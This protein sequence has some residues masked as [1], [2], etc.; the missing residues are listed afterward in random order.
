[1]IKSIARHALQAITGTRKFYYRKLAA[2]APSAKG[3]RVLEIGS[4]K[5]VRGKET[6]SAVH[7]FQD[8]AEF[9][10]TD[11]NPEFGHE[12]LDITTMNL[13]GKYD[14]ILCLNVLEHVYDFQTAIQNLHRAL[15]DGGRLVVAVP[16]AFPMHDEPHDY[17]RYTEFALRRMLA[18]FQNI[19]L[20]IN[21]T[22]KA[23]FGL[24]VVAKK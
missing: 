3:K 2:L 15:K 10:Q 9:R 22:R 13:D 8:V 23:P 20:S 1:M 11:M 21:G 19:D 5:Q 6:Y 12:I 17:Y 4:G 18:D 16:F 14:L 7:I 24:F